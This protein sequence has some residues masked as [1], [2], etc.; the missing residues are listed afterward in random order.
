MPKREPLRPLRRAFKRVEHFTKLTI[1]EHHTF[2]KN[3]Y[4]G[5]ESAHNLVN[6]AVRSPLLNTRDPEAKLNAVRS[7]ILIL[8]L[9]EIKLTKE[10]EGDGDQQATDR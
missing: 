3:P 5:H 2:D 9:A 8:C 7:C 1:G 6:M 4:I 10:V